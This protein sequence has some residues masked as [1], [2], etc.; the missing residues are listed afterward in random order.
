[1][2][3]N[4]YSIEEMIQLIAE[5]IKNEKIIADYKEAEDIEII[6]EDDMTS[7]FGETYFNYNTYSN[8]AYLHNRHLYIYISDY[9]QYQLDRG[10]DPFTGEFFGEVQRIDHHI[11]PSFDTVQLYEVENDDWW[12]SSF[13]ME[14]LVSTASLNEGFWPYTSDSL[15]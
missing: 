2:R 10:Y 9:E 15:F 5:Y 11:L 3:E 12:R 7:L 1:M 4:Y 13:T 14:E 8:V 6:T